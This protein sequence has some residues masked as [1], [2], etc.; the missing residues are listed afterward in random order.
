MLTCGSVVVDKWIEFFLISQQV[1]MLYFPFLSK[2]VCMRGKL[3]L[4]LFN[5][6]RERHTHTHLLLIYLLKACSIYFVNIKNRMRAEM[7][8]LYW[9][10]ILLG[11][12]AAILKHCNW[13]P[14][15]EYCCLNKALSQMGAIGP[16]HTLNTQITNL[17]QQSRLSFKV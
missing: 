8:P 7:D 12:G 16:V 9:K 17:N 5:I 1:L 4:V 13:A 6:Y 10:W 15:S 14:Q 2:R 11:L 3:V